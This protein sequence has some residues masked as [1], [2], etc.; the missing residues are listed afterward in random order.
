M[1][2]ENIEVELCIHRSDQSTVKEAGHLSFSL[3]RGQAIRVSSSMRENPNPDK[4]EYVY[5]I[6]EDLLEAVN[7]LREKIN[8]QE[9]DSD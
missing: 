2:R 7:L 6:Y 5:V 9:Y 3:D 1:I 8:R 4:G